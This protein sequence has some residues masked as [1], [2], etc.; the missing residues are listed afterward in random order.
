MP[1]QVDRIE[2]TGTCRRGGGRGY[3]GTVSVTRSGKRCQ[4]WSSQHPHQ[5]PMVP[6]LFIS[7][8]DDLYNPGHSYCRNPGGLGKQ[9]WCYTNSRTVR[10]EYCNIPKCGKWLRKEK[11]Q[12]H[13]LPGAVGCG[14]AVV[15]FWLLSW[16]CSHLKLT[17][18]V[19]M[20]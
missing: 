13:D 2:G 3:R 8:L 14:M 18:L 7:D 17:F 11:R 6:Q 20:F 16:S 9:P 4:S 1:G 19:I 10:W 15:R 12:W 5:H